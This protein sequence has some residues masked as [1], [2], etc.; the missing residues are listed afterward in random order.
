MKLE[1]IASSERLYVLVARRIA[2]YIGQGNAQP[3][4][5]L[6]SE[7]DLAE[8]LNVSRPTVRE[9]MIALEV[10]GVIEVR[11][12]SGIYVASGGRSNPLRDEGIGPF[13]ILELRLMV[14]PEAAALAAERMTPAQV[15]GLRD[16]V[17]DMA[18]TAESPER[19]TVDARFH[20]ALAHGTEN[21]AI[22][23]TIEWLWNLRAQSAQSRGF[24]RTILSEGIYPVIDEHRAIVEAVASGSA[25]AARQAM[26]DHLTAA[27]EAAARHFGSST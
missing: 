7:R 3:G 24:H 2:D 10:S 13:H 16:I 17:D 25:D 4:D 8:R 19:E 27:T 9:A 23:G 14:E 21:A 11:K 26:R 5:K 15:Q 1:P 18:R 20:V 6:P 22:V 12:G